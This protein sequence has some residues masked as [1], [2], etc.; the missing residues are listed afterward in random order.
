MATTSFAFTEAKIRNL[1]PPDTDDPN[2]RDYHKD[3]KC[4]GLQVAVFPSGNE[5]FISSAGSTA[6]LPACD[7][8]QPTELS[9]DQAREAARIHAGDVA[10]GRNPQAARRAKR[11]EAKLSDLWTSYLDLHA[12]PR[13]KSWKDDERQWKSIW[14]HW[15]AS[16]YPLSPRPSSPSGMATSPRITARCKRTDARPSGDDVF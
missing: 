2:T 5:S 3:A 12:K 1:K 16:D 14:G 8:G 7:W 13:K 9:V 15:Q 10:A 6:G 11:E 4:L